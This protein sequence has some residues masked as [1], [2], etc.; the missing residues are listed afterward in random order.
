MRLVRSRRRDAQGRDWPITRC[1]FNELVIHN[2]VVK[3]YMLLLI[4][5]RRET[6]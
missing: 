4:Q 6:L 2:L 5:L 1:S 3:C